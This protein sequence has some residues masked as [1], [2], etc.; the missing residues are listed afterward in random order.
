[1]FNKFPLGIKFVNEYTA[2]FVKLQFLC[3]SLDEGININTLL[4]VIKYIIKSN[5]MHSKDKP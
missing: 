4:N 1:M 2:T 5:E 3:K